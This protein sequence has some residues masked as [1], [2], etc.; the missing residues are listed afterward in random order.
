MEAYV[1]RH[2]AVAIEPGICYGQTDVP[3]AETF[4]D[5]TE[6]VRQ[7]L[8][9]CRDIAVYSSP[10]S[11]CRELAEILSRGNMLTDAR[12]MEM[13]FGEW[14]KRRWD[15]IQEE[16]FIRWMD[17]FVSQRCAGGESYCDLFCRAVAFWEDLL[18]T[19]HPTVIIVTH[20]GVIR[21]L[22]A[23]WL[24]IPLRHAMRIGV[25]FGGVTKVRQT[26]YGPVVEYVNR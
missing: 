6:K 24:E 8:P 26:D 7:K 25:D 20:G 5:E 10:L 19:E 2:T 22:L 17:D 9:E 18:K 13:H 11:R 21:A 3:V 4:V 14:E 1:I 23:H 15:D 16:Q 12:L